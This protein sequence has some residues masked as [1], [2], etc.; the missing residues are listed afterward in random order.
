MV[1]A[2]LSTDMAKHASDLELFKSG[3][4]IKEITGESKNGH[5]FIDRTDA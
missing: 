3:L 2:I 5:L 1:G 4:D